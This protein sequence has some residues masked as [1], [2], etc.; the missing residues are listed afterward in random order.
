MISYQLVQG[1]GARGWNSGRGGLR[2][3]FSNLCD[4][5]IVVVA[6]AERPRQLVAL[7][8][9]HAQ[10]LCGGGEEGRQVRRRLLPPL[11]GHTEV[12]P[13]LLTCDVG[14][15]GAEPLVRGPPLRLLLPCP[16]RVAQLHRRRR[17]KGAVGSGVPQGHGVAVRLQARL[18]LVQLRLERRGLGALSTVAGKGLF[19][20]LK[21]V[22]LLRAE[23]RVAEVRPRRAQELRVGQEAVVAGLARGQHLAAAP[24]LQAHLAGPERV[25]RVHRAAA[26]SSGDLQGRFAAAAWWKPKGCRRCQRA[27]FKGPPREPSHTS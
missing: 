3:R 5:H 9:N 18:Q 19:E 22:P 24:L 7:P 12:P 8:H 27:L 26:V 21:D 25:L 17:H 14:P 15:D 13:S 16:H 1:G 10:P 2:R 23:P 6:K 11:L 4:L 20:D